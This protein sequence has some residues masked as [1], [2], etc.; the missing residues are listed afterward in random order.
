M[1]L[2]GMER[3]AKQWEQWGLSWDETGSP[4]PSGGRCQV[5]QGAEDY[6]DV[7]FSVTKDFK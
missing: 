5:I 3:G 4:R 7:L 1:A 2:G 6:V